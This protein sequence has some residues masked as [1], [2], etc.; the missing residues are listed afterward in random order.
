MMITIR[1]IIASLCLAFAMVLFVAPHYES[2]L[3]G[4]NYPYPKAYDDAVKRAISQSIEWASDRDIRRILSRV[5]EKYGNEITRISKKYRTSP[6]DITALI[7]T[8]SLGDETAVSGKGAIGLMGVK[9][10]TGSDMGFYDVRDPTEN[11]HAGTKYYRWLMDQFLDRE[12][13][14]AAYN[15]GPGNVK[16]RLE[17][18]FDPEA[19][20]YIWKM[21]RIVHIIRESRSNGMQDDREINKTLQSLLARSGERSD[22]ATGSP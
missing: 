9:K 10:T 12:L 7:I 1:K 13:A 15:L 22:T 5:E 14:L 11:L 21:R 4:E 6:D 18:G 2:Q 16:K 8:E 20:K 3:R 17:D 19:M